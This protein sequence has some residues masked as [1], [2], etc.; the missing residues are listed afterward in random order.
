MLFAVTFMA[1]TL[2]IPV[3]V[4]QEAS[5]ECKIELVEPKLD[6]DKKVVVNADQEVTIRV[7]IKN[8]PKASSPDVVLAS[9]LR[10]RASAGSNFG[11]PKWINDAEVEYKTTVR[12]PRKPGAYKLEIAPSPATASLPGAPLKSKYPTVDVTVK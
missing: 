8:L 3:G 6:R 5:G 11:R 1:L 4:T 7:R 10:G 12:S 2:P 9:F